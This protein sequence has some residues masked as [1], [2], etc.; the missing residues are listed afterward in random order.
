M[1]KSVMLE[2]CMYKMS[3]TYLIL[4]ISRTGHAS[5]GSNDLGWN[6]G[7]PVPALQLRTRSRPGGSR[8]E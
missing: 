8:E 5:C 4:R 7:Q 6:L 1:Q 2:T 3:R